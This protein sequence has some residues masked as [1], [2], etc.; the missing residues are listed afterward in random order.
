MT[1]RSRF[2]EFRASIPVTAVRLEPSEL[3]GLLTRGAAT[4]PKPRL[5]ALE[6]PRRLA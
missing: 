6:W 5:V 1:E 4:W 2:P 3:T